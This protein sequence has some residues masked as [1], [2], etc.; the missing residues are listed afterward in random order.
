MLGLFIRLPQI[1][2]K[3][4]HFQNAQPRFEKLDYRAKNAHK[5]TKTDEVCKFCSLPCIMWNLL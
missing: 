3:M 4:F 2:C 5:Q 1:L